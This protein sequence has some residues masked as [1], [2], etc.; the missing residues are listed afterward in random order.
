MAG[1]G[2]A[3]AGAA[4]A[5][6]SATFAASWP[7]AGAA[8]AGVALASCSATFTAPW[9]E[10]AGAGVVL[11]SFS[12]SCTACWVGIRSATAVVFVAASAGVACWPT[13]TAEAAT[14]DAIRTPV[15]RRAGVRVRPRRMSL[16]RSWAAGSSRPRT[17]RAGSREP[18]GVLAGC[19]RHAR[20]THALRA[21]PVERVRGADPPGS[22][23]L[24]RAL[25][26]RWVAAAFR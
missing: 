15:V 25:S 24:D 16:Q 23:V 2:L 18:L 17:G 14:Q 13:R 3:A 5:S 10:A 6:C 19:S 21:L 20:R 12:A 7:E 22:P 26:R 8:G 1:A 4:L 11:A 9:P